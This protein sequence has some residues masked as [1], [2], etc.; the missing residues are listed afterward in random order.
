MKNNSK[1]WKIKHF[2]QLYFTLAKN[3]TILMNN[4][5]LGINYIF[6]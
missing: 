2:Y 3:E 4:H 5:K 6:L 1:F